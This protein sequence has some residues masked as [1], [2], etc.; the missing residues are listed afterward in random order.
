MKL[1][2]RADLSLGVG[3]GYEPAKTVKSRDLFSSLRHEVS[4]L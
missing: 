2:T 3:N 1:R 4:Q